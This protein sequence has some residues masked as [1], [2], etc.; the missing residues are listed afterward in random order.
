MLALATGGAKVALLA[1][2][3][4]AY[5]RGIVGVVDG[6]QVAADLATAAG[7]TCLVDAFVLWLGWVLRCRGRRPGLVVGEV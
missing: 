5:A 3:A 2:A 6:T 4:A 1:L 7:Y